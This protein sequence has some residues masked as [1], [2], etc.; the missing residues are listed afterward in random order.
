MKMTLGFNFDNCRLKEL[1]KNKKI[2]MNE[3]L[4]ALLVGLL[5]KNA[6][7]MCDQ[8]LS[9][10]INTQTDLVLNFLLQTISNT[11]K[12]MNTRK[13]ALIY[14][15]KKILDLIRQIPEESSEQIYQTI[16]D[17]FKFFPNNELLFIGFQVEQIFLKLVK[18]NRANRIIPQFLNQISP[19]NIQLSESYLNCI[20]T[21]IKYIDISIFSQSITSFLSL[22]HSIISNKDITSSL[23]LSI[24]RLIYSLLV[25]PQLVQPLLETGPIIFTIM[26]SLSDPDLKTALSDFFTNFASVHIL[27]HSILDSFFPFLSHIASD[28]SH[29]EPVRYLSFDI[30]NLYIEKFPELSFPYFQSIIRSLIIIISQTTN[31]SLT[32]TIEEQS[33]VWDLAE[34]TLM[35]IFKI[36]NLTKFEKPGRSIGDNTFNLCVEL[37]ETGDSIK[38]YSA[39]VVLKQLVQCIKSSVNDGFCVHAFINFIKSPEPLL[40]LAASKLYIEL[41]SILSIPMLVETSSIFIEHFKIVLFSEPIEIVRRYN[42]RAFSLFIRYSSVTEIA[43]N[44]EKLNPIEWLT[45]LMTLKPAPEILTIIQEIGKRYGSTLEPILADLFRLFGTIIEESDDGEMCTQTLISIL[46][47]ME[48]A[49]P[50]FVFPFLKTIIHLVAIKDWNIISTSDLDIF[51]GTFAQLIITAPLECLTPS[52]SE[53]LPKIKAEISNLPQI[54][55]SPRGSVP[56]SNTRIVPLSD[57][58]FLQYNPYEFA[59]FEKILFL[60]NSIFS[61]I[62]PHSEFASFIQPLSALI[63]LNPFS[64]SALL[65]VIESAINMQTEILLSV[66]A[67]RPLI[68][69]SFLILIQTFLTSCTY[70]AI[71]N[72]SFLIPFFDLTPEILVLI[73]GIIPRIHLTAFKSSSIRETE[74]EGN[75]ISEEKKNDFDYLTA[76]L[77][78][79]ILKKQPSTVEMIFSNFNASGD[80]YSLILQSFLITHGSPQLKDDVLSSAFALL[81]ISNSA[82]SVIAG[83]DIISRLMKFGFV[84]S[85]D[86]H[87]NW[88]QISNGLLL[89]FSGNDSFWPEL[90]LIHS[91]NFLRRIFQLTPNFITIPDFHDTMY[92]YVSSQLL[93][94]LPIKTI[95]HPSIKKLYQFLCTMILN[96]PY[97]L[98]GE[99]QLLSIIVIFADIMRKP[100]FTEDIRMVL[101]NFIRTSFAENPPLNN[102][103]ADFA[104]RANSTES[105]I[106][107]LKYFGKVLT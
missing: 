48:Y 62:G 83:F 33:N 50:E 34:A 77:L 84:S 28:T 93:P 18:V 76:T 65:N 105:R 72:S 9:D 92:S 56:Q 27:F 91:C 53:L 35:V 61:I 71:L 70:T 3:Q 87:T 74:E 78:Y 25:F 88:E 37:I 75:N 15:Q 31:D 32:D 58:G 51:L 47:F 39:L 103:I 81:D 101:E 13:I 57:G 106:N 1:N 97:I 12:P 24:F 49:N 69:P 2:L 90:F 94:I 63:S 41:T 86:I 22:I 95:F 99:E 5:D 85:E 19:S 17:F 64:D 100:Y 73:L 55:Y 79:K 104:D 96:T 67:A 44:S 46:I 54:S 38:Q 107:L 7:T 98:H 29:S 20:S 16:I 102:S 36:C 21:I 30:L 68:A 59:A 89:N 80:I 82:S 4:D 26:S 45:Q 10:L 40:R 11:E 60:L 8:S 14:L 43:S 23:Q 42:L 66:E 52:I 6:S